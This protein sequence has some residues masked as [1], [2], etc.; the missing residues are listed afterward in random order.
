MKNNALSELFKKHRK[1][2]RKSQAE[3]AKEIGFKYKEYYSSLERGGTLPTNRERR[4]AMLNALNLN[5]N[6][7][8]KVILAESDVGW[9]KSQNILCL[10]KLFAQSQCSKCTIEDLEFFVA[11]QNK[12]Q[13]P[14]T[15]EVLD[16]LMRLRNPQNGE[17]VPTPQ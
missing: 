7:I 10:I 5:E 3:V 1:V 17:S 8:S 12:L 11:L 9:V 13:Q 6:D 15:L 16:Q 2:L 4:Q 14:I